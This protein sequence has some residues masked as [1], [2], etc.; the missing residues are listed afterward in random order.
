MCVRR[1]AHTVTILNISLL[2]SN[3]FIDYCIQQ[4]TTWR[5]QHLNIFQ[6]VQISQISPRLP[7]IPLNLQIGKCQQPLHPSL[8]ATP[9]SPL[10]MSKYTFHAVT[11]A[12]INSTCATMHSSP[13]PMT[14]SNAA[15]PYPCACS[16]CSL[17]SESTRVN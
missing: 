9:P 16:A 11:H 6:L 1:I 12:S 17:R 15:S 14:F 10:F 4:C 7:F 2:S 3:S 13:Q 5:H 8:P